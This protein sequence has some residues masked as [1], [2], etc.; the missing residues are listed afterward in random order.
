MRIGALVRD[1]DILEYVRCLETT[2]DRGNGRLPTVLVNTGLVDRG[3]LLVIRHDWQV[4]QS[5]RRHCYTS[6]LTD[7]ALLSKGEGTASLC[8]AWLY[9]FLIVGMARPTCA[10]ERRSD[11]SRLGHAIN[12]IANWRRAATIRSEL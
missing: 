8:I 10:C 3:L 5:V 1:F 7:E 4:L 9:F 6:G 11:E 12:T 2:S